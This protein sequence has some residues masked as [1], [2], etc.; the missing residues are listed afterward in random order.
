M[1]RVCY[2]ESLLFPL[3]LSLTVRLTLTLTLTLTQTLAPWRVGL[4]AQWTF[5]IADRRNSGPV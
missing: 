1:I 4:S 3:T 2:S 5:G